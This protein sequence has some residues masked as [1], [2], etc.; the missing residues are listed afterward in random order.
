MVD[1]HG[2]SIAMTASETGESSNIGNA[3]YRDPHE[4]QIT[5]EDNGNS[6]DPN[7]VPGSLRFHG[8]WS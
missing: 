8:N 5:W 6:I 4:T 2:F 1:L 3:I 7:R